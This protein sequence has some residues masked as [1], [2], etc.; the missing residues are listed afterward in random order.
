MAKSDSIGYSRLL[1]YWAFHVSAWSL[2]EMMWLNPHS[3]PL[4]LRLGLQTTLL[5]VLVHIRKSKKPFPHLIIFYPHADHSLAT[6]SAV[7]CMRSILIRRSTHRK[8]YSLKL[9]TGCRF[10][11]KRL[12]TNSSLVWVS[13]TESRFVWVFPTES[14]PCWRLPTEKFKS[15]RITHRKMFL[16]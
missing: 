4:A 9:P 10:V 14:C 3:L 16:F 1:G 11:R 8:T 12:P 5:A 7:H 13:P 2:K 6:A 15:Y